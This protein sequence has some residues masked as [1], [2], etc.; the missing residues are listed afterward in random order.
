MLGLEDGFWL[1]LEYGF[2]IGLKEGLWLGF[3]DGFWLGLE[4]GFWLGLEDGFWLGL[5]H[6]F[7]L[8]LRPFTSDFGLLAKFLDLGQLDGV[9]VRHQF[10]HPSH[11]CVCWMV[12]SIMPMHVFLSVLSIG[13]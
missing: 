7:R 10:C 8:G 13:M 3:E 5:E 4:E 12:Q 2:W 1:G 6:G 9:Q 11:D